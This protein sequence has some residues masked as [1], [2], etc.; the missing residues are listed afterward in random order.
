MRDRREPKLELKVW[1]LSIIAE[2][3][4]AINAMRWPLR[5]VLISMALAVLLFALRQFR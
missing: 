4:D 2:G 3:R 1:P 5:L